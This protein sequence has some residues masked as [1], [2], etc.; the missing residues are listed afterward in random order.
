M[1]VKETI[2]IIY[3]AGAYGAYLSWCLYTLT[4]DVDVISP[5]TEVGSSH[6]F[7]GVKPLNGIKAWNEYVSINNPVKFVRMHIKN[8]KEESISTNLEI[9]LSTVDK[10]IYIYPDRNSV[11]LNINNIYSKVTKEWWP[12]P[13]KDGECIPKAEALQFFKD[14]I[15]QNWP[16]STTVQFDNIPRWIKREFL[17]LNLVP[18]WHAQVE[19]FHP[20]SWQ[21]PNCLIFFIED[22]LH[23]FKPTIQYLQKFLNLDFKKDIDQLIPIHKEMLKRQ[24]NYGQDLLCN[25]IVNSTIQSIDFS[26]ADSYLPLH[27]ES[28]IQWQLRNLGFEIQCHGL[29]IFPTN[30]MKLKK[31]LYKI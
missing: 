4:T 7:S 29:D 3:N 18:S 20:D 9:I 15:Y 25:Q 22:L 28:W 23:N 17:S 10:M 11:L 27:S 12:A 1:T 2:P 26:W 31:L 19:W 24:I 6:N 13:G 30:S 5:L 21:H 14:T 16:V 8:R